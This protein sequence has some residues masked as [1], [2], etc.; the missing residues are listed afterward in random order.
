VKSGDVVNFG[1]TLRP[2]FPIRAKT[3]S[4]SC[5]EYYAPDK[6]GDAKPALLEV[7]E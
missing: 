6:V 1:Y 3:P 4:S 5:Y 2:R 7:T